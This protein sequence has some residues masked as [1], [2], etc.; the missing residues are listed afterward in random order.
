[1]MR[2]RCLM[3]VLYVKSQFLFY[4]KVG[5]CTGTL[6][7]LWLAIPQHAMYNVLATVLTTVLTP[8]VIN[9]TP[10]W[11]VLTTHTWLD[12]VRRPCVRRTI[13]LPSV[14]I[15][16]HHHTHHY[17]YRLYLRI[18]IFV[19]LQ[20]LLYIYCLPPI[21]LKTKHCNMS[22]CICVCIAVCCAY[23]G[24][25]MYMLMFI[26]CFTLL[27]FIL[28]SSKHAYTITPQPYSL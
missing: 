15:R 28:I 20:G 18:S 3:V 7:V 17:T 10:I 25:I 2:L 5:H 1:M 27:L 16:M 11:T 22:M 23:C 6:S 12:Y 19:V 13:C 4:R 8:T 24:T 9:T 14:V 26:Y 21:M